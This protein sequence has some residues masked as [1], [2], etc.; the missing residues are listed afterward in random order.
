MINQ[1]QYIKEMCLV[2]MLILATPYVI[3]LTKYRDPVIDSHVREIS[4]MLKTVDWYATFLVRLN[5]VII[6][7]HGPR[8]TRRSGC[9]RNNPRNIEVTCFIIM[10]KVEV[11]LI[12]HEKLESMCNDNSVLLSVQKS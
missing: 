4:P 9:Y 11:I 7:F 10:W 8:Q 2:V 6:H 1:L 12:C 5:E 3:S